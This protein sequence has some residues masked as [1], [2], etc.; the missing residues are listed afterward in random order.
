MTVS[1]PV[2]SSARSGVPLVGL[3][4]LLALLLTAAAL[5]LL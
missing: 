2:I 5:L 1:S 4:V 3:L